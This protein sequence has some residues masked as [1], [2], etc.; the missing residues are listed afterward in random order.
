VEQRGKMLALYK[1]T[2]I[3]SQAIKFFSWSEYSHASWVTENG[4]EYE[5]WD[6]VGVQYSAKFGA[7]HTKG[8]FV[9]LF[10]IKITSQETYNLELFFKSQ[11]GKK[12][13]YKGIL[14]FLMRKDYE[15]VEKWF[16]SELIMEGFIKI[17]NPVLKN[18]PSYKVY[19]G[20]LAYSPLFE[21]VKTIVI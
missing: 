2:S 16:C 9:D 8:T 19:P 14:G 13:D 10:N 15:S 1:G 11:I 7:A 21:K 6:G 18:I 17:N 5:S 3:V 4:G 12:Y 20:M